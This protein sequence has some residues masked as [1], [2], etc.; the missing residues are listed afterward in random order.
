MG[1]FLLSRL[2]QLLIVALLISM[3]LFVVL[4]LL[5]GDPARSVL[6][7]RAT[8]AQLRAERHVLG[9]DKPLVVQFADFASNA[10]RGNLGRSIQSGDP[11]TSD[12]AHALPVTLELI[13]SALVLAVVVGVALGATAAIRRGGAIDKFITVLASINSGV[14]SFVWGLVLVLIVSLGFRLLPSAGYVSPFSDPAAGIKSLLLP[15]IALSLPSIGIMARISRAVLVDVLDQPYIQ[16]ARSKGVGRMRIYMLHALKNGAVPIVALIGTEFAY[17]L[18]DTIAVESVFAMPG[19][20]K[21]MLDAFLA[22]DYPM[23]QGVA[24]VIAITV[25]VVTLLSDLASFA[26]DRRIM[27]RAVTA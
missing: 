17:I 13:I 15:V 22:R 1:R 9:L 7:L 4:R 10:L 11:V 19:V 14:P 8:A 27:Q 18:G 3:V 26:L 12:L 23:I 25:M 21:L 16:F 2:V 6:G 5:P 20:G 24:L